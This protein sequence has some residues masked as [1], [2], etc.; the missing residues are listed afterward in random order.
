MFPIAIVQV[1]DEEPQVSRDKG[2]GVQAKD[3]EPWIGVV[4]VKVEESKASTAGNSQESFAAAV[5]NKVSSGRKRDKKR[6]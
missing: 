5:V 2:G 6:P 1:Q 3:Q 4:P